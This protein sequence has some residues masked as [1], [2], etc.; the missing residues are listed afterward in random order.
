[1]PST[2]ATL[3]SIVDVRAQAHHLV[4]VH[5]AVFEDGLGHHARGAGAMHI[6]RHELRL[7]V[8][9]EARVFGGAE[10]SAPSDA[11]QAGALG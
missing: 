1:M 8:G 9:R 6:Q 11:S 4:H 7:H 3:P 10:S 5:E 2:I